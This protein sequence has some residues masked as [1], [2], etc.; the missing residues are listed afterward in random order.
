MINGVTAILA[1]TPLVGE[2]I[3]DL[4]NNADWDRTPHINIC[5]SSLTIVTM[6]NL[7]PLETKEAKTLEIS[8][9]TMYGIEYVKKKTLKIL[10]P[11]VIV[12]SSQVAKCTKIVTFRYKTLNYYQQQCKL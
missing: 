7:Y 3:R 6:L 1:V 2:F 10:L 5:H 12:T 8:P 9:L 4:K 11:I